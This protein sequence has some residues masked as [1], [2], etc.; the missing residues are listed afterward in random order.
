MIPTLII[1][2]NA[3]ARADLTRKLKAHPEVAIVGEAGTAGRA[4]TLLALGGYDLVF[5]DIRLRGGNGFDL[6]PL[7]AAEARIIFVTAYDEYAL[8]AFE[9]N[10]LD[11]LLKPVTA[12]RLAQSLSRLGVETGP[13]APPQLTE[14][15][16][17]HV[18]TDAGSQFIAVSSIA[19]IMAELNYTLIHLTDGSKLLIRRPLK[20]WADQLDANTFVR[21]S[22]ES[23]VNLR[24]IS[25]VERNDTKSGTVKMTGVK[26]PVPVSRRRWATLKAK[27]G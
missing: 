6:V 8:R 2:D 11:Y 20:S 18:R 22:R 13:A 12:E 14:T 23:I 21:V 5:L 27:A 19:A 1:E 7:V 15:D 25:H 4:R 17:V 26:A 10:A 24:H 16:L 9:V 3:A